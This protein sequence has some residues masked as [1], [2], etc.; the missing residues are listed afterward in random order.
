MR[1]RNRKRRHPRAP[2]W[3]AFPVQPLPP[4]SPGVAWGPLLPSPGRASAPLPEVL[5][6]QPP[7]APATGLIPAAA[8][9]RAGAGTP[10]A[11]FGSA[12]QHGYDIAVVNTPHT[13]LKSFYNEIYFE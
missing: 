6:P 1:A 7:E 11:A 12:F 13:V 9:A 10:S 8:P 3:A 4:P 2:P 5:R